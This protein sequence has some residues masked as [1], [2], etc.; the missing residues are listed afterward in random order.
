MGDHSYDW[1]ASRI[2]IAQGDP[3]VC[4]PG[5][6]L[7]LADRDIRCEHG[8]TYDQARAKGVLHDC[9]S[10]GWYFSPPRGSESPETLAAPCC[11]QSRALLARAEGAEELYQRVLLALTEAGSPAGPPRGAEIRILELGERARARP[12]TLQAIADRAIEDLKTLAF[13]AQETAR[14]TEPPAPAPADPYPVLL[15]EATLAVCVSIVESES[16]LPSEPSA[17]ELARF[18]AAPM[19]TMRAIVRATKR[20]IA[21]RMRA[22]VPLAPPAAPAP[23]ETP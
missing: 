5:C 6:A 16:E 21:Q 13:L 10:Q 23:E 4:T 11:A 9:P 1:D 17:E 19:A 12:L 20:C 7:C 2:A 15:D 22:L 18:H 14:R 3:P 8:F